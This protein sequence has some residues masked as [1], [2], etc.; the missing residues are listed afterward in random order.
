MSQSHTRT[1]PPGPR[2]VRA[3]RGPPP[4]RNRSSDE[5]LAY[6]AGLFQMLASTTRLRI[7]EALAEGELCVGDLA[8]LVGVS[9]SAVS[10]QLRQLRQMRLVRYRKNGKLALYRLDDR[11]VEFL[12]RTGLE[13]VREGTGE[14]SPG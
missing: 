11:H 4:P 5:E 8:D 14:D 7:I 13:H 10:H 1:E 6:L 12:F 2:A 3:H 9:H